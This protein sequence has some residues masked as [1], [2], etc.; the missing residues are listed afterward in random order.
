MVIWDLHEELCRRCIA[1]PVEFGVPQTE[2]GYATE[3]FFRMQREKERASLNETSHC[4]TDQRSS[5]DLMDRMVSIDSLTSGASTSMFSRPGSRL[6]GNGIPIVSPVARSRA[7][8]RASRDAMHLPSWM[9]KADGLSD[10]GFLDGFESTSPLYRPPKLDLD[11]LSETDDESINL[12]MKLKRGHSLVPS[13]FSDLD[14]LPVDD[15]MPGY[16]R[17]GASF[18]NSRFNRPVDSMRW[19]G[20]RSKDSMESSPIYNLDPSCSLAQYQDDH[21]RPV[22]H[23]NPAESFDLS[24]AFA[25]PTGPEPPSS[26]SCASDSR[27]STPFCLHPP[28]CFETEALLRNMCESV[29]GR[30]EQFVLL[31]SPHSSTGPIGPHIHRIASRTP[32]SMYSDDKTV[33]TRPN[34]E[35]HTTKMFSD[36]RPNSDESVSPSYT[37]FAMDG[38]LTYWRPYFA[39]EDIEEHL[40]ES[41][42]DEIAGFR[43]PTDR[44][45]TP[46]AKVGGRMNKNPLYSS[47]S[48]KN[49]VKSRSFNVFLELSD[50]PCYKTRPLDANLAPLAHEYSLEEVRRSFLRPKR[51]VFIL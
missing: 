21:T 12:F 46:I 7:I 22:Y 43:C 13:R 41:E 19:G 48:G 49:T 45:D 1:L 38:N 51:S 3:L 31:R 23:H 33:Y 25:R 44:C 47:G 14:S 24:M 4:I 50:R 10:D 37:P 35:E 2:T 5:E 26:V 32:A 6:S 18:E 42:S 8:P 15:F 17:R 30:D 40:T 9:S 39:G 36:M 11:N 27:N 34:S 16:S 28:S 20:R 29:D